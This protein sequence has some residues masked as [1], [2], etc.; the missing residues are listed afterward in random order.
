MPEKSRTKDDHDDEDDLGRREC[1]TAK[2]LVLIPAIPSLLIVLVVVVVVVLAH[3]S[4][5]ANV[6][7]GRREVN[8]GSRLRC[9]CA[10]EI[11]N[12]DVIVSRADSSS[13]EYSLPDSSTTARLESLGQFIFSEMDDNS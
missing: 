11:E 13:S 6:S 3:E 12:E 5:L 2:I 4:M 8:G 10:G 1:Q 7:A 9:A